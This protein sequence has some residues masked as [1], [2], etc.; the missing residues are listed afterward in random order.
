M[1]KIAIIASILAL[2]GCSGG[3]TPQ[4][5]ICEGD[6]KNLSEGDTWT[7]KFASSVQIKDGVLSLDGTTSTFG[8]PLPLVETWVSTLEKEF[9]NTACIF[10]GRL[11]YHFRAVSMGTQ[12]FYMN[13]KTGVYSYYRIYRV[14]AMDGTPSFGMMESSNGTCRLLGS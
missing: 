6:T 5:W 12:D 13:L 7:T 2:G 1:K 11:V 4:N 10:Q 3:S 9:V 8:G 14:P